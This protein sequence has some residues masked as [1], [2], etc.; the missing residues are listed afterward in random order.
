MQSI[1]CGSS[2]FFLRYFPT[3][4][5]SHPSLMFILPSTTTCCP[6]LDGWSNLWPSLCLAEEAFLLRQRLMLI[7][8][9]L[10]PQ[11][12]NLYAFASIYLSSGY[13][14][15]SGMAHSPILISRPFIPTI[16]PRNS[17]FSLLK[18]K[19]DFDFWQSCFSHLCHFLLCRCLFNCKR[20]CSWHF[21][22]RDA[23]VFTPYGA[24]SP[25][26][27]DVIKIL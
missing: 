17:T 9:R 20:A 7:V 21:S 8:T 12:I 19:R 14:T 16:T 13:L 22:I 6:V 25:M 3:P 24:L 26:F 2:S 4:F 10:L 1:Q 5:L 18:E 15:S 27:Y 11:P 23:P